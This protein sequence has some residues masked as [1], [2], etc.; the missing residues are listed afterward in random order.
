MGKSRPIE[1]R[2]W[3]KV[4]KTASCWLW[5]GSAG[6]FG[7]G[8]LH[9][10]TKYNRK[11]LRTHR[12]SWEIHN[13][14]VPDG[15][16]V[17]HKCD[18]PKCVNPDHLFLGTHKDNAQDCMKKGRFVPGGYRRLTHCKNG[19][20]FT[21]ENTRISSEGRRMCKACAV[22]RYPAVNAK[23]RKKYAEDAKTKRRVLI[24]FNGEKLSSRQID[25]KLG[26]AFGT[27]S[28]R[29]RD[30]W[31][32]NQAIEMPRQKNGADRNCAAAIRASIGDGK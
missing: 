2:F 32:L 30:G 20:E 12:L 24:D 3:E 10:G 15:L 11:L 23:Q 29:L 9:S 22:A 25:E 26:L 28:R 13:G 1:D 21:E 14:K 18:N 6:G 4:V 31:P 16:C 8:Q 7:Y 19:H 5:T 17:L 27:V